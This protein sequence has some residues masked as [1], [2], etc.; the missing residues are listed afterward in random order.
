MKTA[1][2][3]REGHSGNFLYSVI[4]SQ[5]ADDVSFRMADNYQN[6]QN[7]IFLT[8]D[9]NIGNQQFDQV[10]RILPVRNIYNPIYNI[11]MKK[12]LLEEFPT[13]E[14]KNWTNDIVFWYDK[15]YYQIQYY[16]DQICK[17]IA[18]NTI[19]NII[20][21][22]RLTDCNYLSDV[23]LQ[24]FR[25]TLNDNQRALIKNYA[26]LQLQ[27]ELADDNT[28]S[29]QEILAPISDDMLLQNPWFWAYAVF[30]F[31]RNNNLTEEQ[32]LWS[33]DA[34]KSPHV[35]SELIQYQYNCLPVR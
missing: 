11:F 24:N 4:T 26:Q 9:Q 25:I 14:M 33:V 3:Y 31:E 34:I 10:L 19:Q 32:R 6:Y 27:V 12:T 21:F 22:D 7:D 20:E 30:K 8:H 2:I 29:M 5:P 15:C 1:I 18:T 13:F 23:L 16:Y 35:C 28:T 17:D